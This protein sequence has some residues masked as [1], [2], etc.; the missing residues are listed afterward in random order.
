MIRFIAAALGIM[1]FGCNRPKTFTCDK[2]P[3]L[4]QPERQCSA[5][6][7]CDRDKCFHPEKAWCFQSSVS[8]A[9]VDFVHNRVGDKHDSTWSG[10][11]QPWCTPTKDEC[12]SIRASIKGAPLKTEC[13][14]L[15]GD[16]DPTTAP[17]S[18]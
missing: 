15:P 2:Q 4:D 11:T 16:Q 10:Y 6:A 7:D 8:W 17:S 9:T 13:R 3:F 1:A 14:E 12:E 5:K 18:Y